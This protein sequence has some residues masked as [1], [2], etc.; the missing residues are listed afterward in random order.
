MDKD[1]AKAFGEFVRTRRLELKLSTHELGR[2]VG[3]RNST[4]TRLE[5]GAFAAPRPDKLARIAEALKLSLA[6]VYA[7][8]GYIVP[9]ELPSFHAYL[10]ARYKELPQAA[11]AEL[12]KLF[13]ELMARHGIDTSAKT[14]DGLERRTLEATS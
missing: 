7:R 5:Q 3:T 11:L 6:D 8:A 13:E 9:G 1:Q 2:I 10:P 12:S 4:I 14:S